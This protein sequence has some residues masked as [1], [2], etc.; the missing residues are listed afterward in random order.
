VRPVLVVVLLLPVVA[1]VAWLVVGSRL[2]VFVDRF[3]TV[4][5]ARLPMGYFELRPDRLVTGGRNWS[6]N[7]P[8]LVCLGAQGRVTLSSGGRTFSF[9]PIRSGRTASPGPFFEFV[10]DPDDEVS[11]ARSRSWLAWPTPFAFNILGPKSPAWKR[12][13]YHRLLWKKASGASIEMIW[14]DEEWFRAK[15]GWAEQYLP[16]DPSV[17]IF[18]SPTERIVER[19]LLRVKGWKREEY[20]LEG[21]GTADGGRSEVIAAVHVDDRNVTSPGTGRSVDLYV[22]RESG[23][24]LR[25]LGGE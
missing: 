20:G 18:P 2:S 17:S 7:P 23:R 14:S 25:E 6:L 15:S 21:R 19:Y 8:Y 11:F 16:L 10:P 9:G 5:D 12:H 13:V 1:S 3:M 4:V 24:V 22:D